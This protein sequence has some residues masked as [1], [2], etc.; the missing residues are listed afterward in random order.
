MYIDQVEYYVLAATYMYM[1]SSTTAF[2]LIR[3]T[4]SIRIYKN[5]VHVQ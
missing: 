2:A 3:E 5:I 4:Q 1:Y